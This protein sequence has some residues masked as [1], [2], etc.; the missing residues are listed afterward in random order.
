MDLASA[1][2]LVAAFQSFDADLATNVAVLW[3]EGRA[4]CAGRNLKYM[5]PAPKATGRSAVQLLLGHT[6]VESTVRYFGIEIDDAL[7]IAQQVDV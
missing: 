1:D 7:A 5:R 3:G 4:F 2:A 6:K